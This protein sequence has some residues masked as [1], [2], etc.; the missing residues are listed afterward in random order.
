VLDE[1]N[2]IKQAVLLAYTLECNHCLCASIPG[3][4]EPPTGEEKG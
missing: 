2:K 4:S 3:A 1:V